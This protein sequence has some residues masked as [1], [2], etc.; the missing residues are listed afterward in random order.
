LG[1]GGAGGSSGATIAHNS[2]LTRGL[3]MPHV[4]HDSPRF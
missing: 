3:A 1:V 4:Y 2:S